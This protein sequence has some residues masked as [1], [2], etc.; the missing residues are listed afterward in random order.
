MTHAILLD[1][2]GIQDYV[3]SSNRLKENLGAS[4][5]VQDIFTSVLKDSIKIVFHQE[6][7]LN[8]WRKPTSVS[9]PIDIGYI[10]GG[11]ALIFVTGTDSDS[12]HQQALEWVKHWTR[13]LLIQ[14]P[15]LGTAVAVD[16]FDVNDF[17]SS[18]NRLFEQ[19]KT[20][21]QRYVPQTHLSSF[22]I[23]AQCNR[24][25]LSAEIWNREPEKGHYISAVAYARI[26]AAKHV[27]SLLGGEINELL[28]DTWAWTTDLE[29]LGQHKEK[30]SHIAI[31]HIDGNNM[32][33]RFQNVA[34]LAEMRQLA[35]TVETATRSAFKQM[36]ETL[37]AK[38]GSDL[39][40]SEDERNDDSFLGIHL[41]EKNGRYL[42]PV[43]PII[44]GGDDITF[45]CDG[46][47]GIYLAK[48]FMEAFEQQPIPNLSSCAGIAITHTKYPFHRGYEMAAA[49][50]RN[51]KQ[52]RKQENN[53]GS[54]L[55][56]QLIYASMTDELGEIR[57]QQ[58]RVSEG[59]LLMRP[60]KLN[61]TASVNGLE[62]A[63]VQTV[64]FKKWPANKRK[65]LRHV[66][67]QDKTKHEEFVTALEYRK[68]KLP[69]YTGENFNLFAGNRT[70]YFDLIELCEL[71]PN[72]EL[73]AVL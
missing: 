24:T 67:S 43:R 21:K 57:Q 40:K 34:S 32:G 41:T 29:K 61:D 10:G 5:L 39:K 30:D 20:N 14:A 69:E 44:L 58:Y 7:D 64:R 31:V 8:A 71:Y 9:T 65:E 27:D 35:H 54:W 51:A 70:P 56:F 49:L 15:G 22:G 55:D 16:V 4:W 47:L 45:V 48:L 66:L 12:E 50:C 1:V 18:Q 37:I 26:Q 72:S 19:L 28:G 52:V 36:L 11:K 62:M 46:R 23:T 33:E 68:L 13:Q 73:K 25:G 6:I 53:N 2:T 63:L 42:L 17:S 3:F 38:L 59:S 60:Y